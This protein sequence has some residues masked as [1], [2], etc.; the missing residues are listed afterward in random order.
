[1]GALAEAGIDIDDVTDKLLRDGVDLFVHALDKLLAGVESKREA[2]TTGRPETFESMIPD[3]LEPAIADR[4]KK[5]ASEDVARRLWSKDETLWGGPGPEMGNRLG[6]LTIS[7]QVLERADELK[8]FAEACWEDGLT[9]AVLLGMGG[10]SLAPEVFRQS[11]GDLPDGLRLH[12]LDSTDPGAILAV[13]RSIDL[14]KT[15]FIVSSKSGGTIET[16][17][18][19]RYFHGRVRDAVGDEAGKHFVAITDPGTSLA[20]LAEENGFLHTF[21]NDPHIAGRS[22]APSDFGLVPA[23]VIGADVAAILERAQVAEQACQHY[24]TAS[25]NSGLW[26]GLAMG[27]LALHRRG[28]LTL[29]GAGPVGSFGLWVEQLIAESTGKEA[30]GVLPVAG[31]SVATPDK[32]GKDRVFIHLQQ[33]DAPETGFATEMAELGKS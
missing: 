2:V 7:D 24:D 29:A 14:A 1:M 23:A 6:W 33:V 21:L 8:A 18:Q 4:V 25:T 19:F 3:E 9:D 11:F 5:A 30:K 28:K 27:E 12:V 10:S 26:L 15:L 16:M 31:E 22:S 20:D 17:S 32:Y 13:E